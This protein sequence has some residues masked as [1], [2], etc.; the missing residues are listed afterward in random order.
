MDAR[1]LTE[2]YWKQ[3]E[4]IAELQRKTNYLEQVVEKMELKLKDME[5]DVKM[6]QGLKR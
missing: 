1:E 5:V 3:K 4:E 6:L 2:K